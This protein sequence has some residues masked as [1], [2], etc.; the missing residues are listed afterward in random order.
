MP[1]IGQRTHLVL[2]AVWTL[3]WFALVEPH[4]GFSW[5]YLRTAAS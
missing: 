2:L 5:H 1:V 4:G 3:L